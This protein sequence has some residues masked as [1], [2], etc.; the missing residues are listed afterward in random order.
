[1]VTIANT[2][3]FYE[4]LKH[5][6]DLA[7]CME[8]FMTPTAMLCDY[9]LPVTFWPERPTINYLGQAN[10][11]IV[12]QRLLPKSVPGKYD[13]RDDYDVWRG[14]S[15][16][17]GLGEYWPWKDLDEA[18]DYRLKNFG[19]TLDEFAQKK[20]WDTDPVTFKSYEKNGFMTPTGKIELWSTIFD[21]LGYDPLPHFEEPGES[22]VSRP[23]L[24]REYPYIL[25]NN[26]KSRWFI[27]S[28]L[29]QSKKLR[30]QKNEPTVKINPDTAKRHGIEAGD[31]VWI[32][33]RRGKIKQKAIISEDVLPEV[34]AVDFGWWFP[35]RPGSEP[36][37]FGVW[38]ANMNILTSDAMDHACEVSGSWYLEGLLCK[39]Y[40]CVEDEN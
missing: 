39:I 17:L 5:Y 19:M 20:G 6:I 33:N 34:I 25:I 27:H 24:A 7:V 12:G 30:E 10:S 29:R 32:E 15:V 2:R 16:R 13:R 23:D 21:A 26:P 31:M 36:D 37:L 28:Q 9:V 18:Q 35:E 22:P 38:D 14:L 3:N 40:K 4:G 1:M 8:I 11:I